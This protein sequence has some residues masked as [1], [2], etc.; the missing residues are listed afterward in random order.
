MKIEL[1]EN[2]LDAIRVRERRPIPLIFNQSLPKI[3]KSFHTKTEFKLKNNLFNLNDYVGE[4]LFF[5]KFSNND[6]YVHFQKICAIVFIS[7]ANDE[8]FYLYIKLHFKYDVL[9]TYRVVYSSSFNDLILSLYKKITLPDFIN[10]S[11]FVSQNDKTTEQKDIIDKYNDLYVI[12]HITINN[13]NFT[14]DLHKRTIITKDADDKIYK[15]RFNGRKDRKYIEQLLSNSDNGAE[16][17][18][19][20][21]ENVEYFILI[22]INNEVTKIFTLKNVNNQQTSFCKKHDNF[23]K[24][25]KVGDI[26]FNVDKQ[27][28]SLSALY[29]NKKYF[30]KINMKKN[31]KYLNDIISLNTDKFKIYKNVY[32]FINSI[33]YETFVIVELIEVISVSDGVKIFTLSQT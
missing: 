22:K 6:D 28:K 29:N 4:S 7:D 20:D 14:I 25:I 2:I 23:T 31:K 21:D 5:K 16:H 8:K 17:I 15:C 18:D 10:S 27:T 32:K 33:Y 9:Y 3:N 26:E 24:R 30:C 11:I 13:I 1:Y 19:E 12:K